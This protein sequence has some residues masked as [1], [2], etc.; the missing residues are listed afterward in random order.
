ML[1]KMMGW[2]TSS[3]GAMI[4]VFARLGANEKFKCIFFDSSELSE[5]DNWLMPNELN[6]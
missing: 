4:K 1:P 5:D 6:I 2:N 3:N